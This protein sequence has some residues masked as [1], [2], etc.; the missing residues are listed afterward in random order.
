MDAVDR[1]FENINLYFTNRNLIYIIGMYKDKAFENVI[2]KYA[3][4]AKAIV[5]VTPKDKS[6]AVEAFELGKLIKDYNEVVT[7]ADS[8]FEALEIAKL[9]A[10][11]KDVILI[12]GSLSFM[13]DFR[14]IIF[15]KTK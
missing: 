12:F 3:P 1:L 11:K 8:Y 2:E 15:A 14:E 6:R 5:T 9:F 4:K 13:S 7:A 10:E